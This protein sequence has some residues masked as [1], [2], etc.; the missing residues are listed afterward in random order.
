LRLA[1]IGSSLEA[2]SG[3]VYD[4]VVT[5]MMALAG[6][7]QMPAEVVELDGTAEGSEAW[8]RT[9]EDGTDRETVEVVVREWGAGVAVAGTRGIV[10][11]VA[12]ERA[13]GPEGA[14]VETD[15]TDDSRVVDA[16]TLARATS[17]SIWRS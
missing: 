9:P 5:T 10:V 4:D 16:R 17:G 6:Y 15:Q 13:P 2:L 11:P 14:R 1:A 12:E 3:R 7:P 8:A